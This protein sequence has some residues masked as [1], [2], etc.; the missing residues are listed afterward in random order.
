MFSS[1]IKVVSEVQNDIDVQIL[2]CISD[3]W[4]QPA[5]LSKEERAALAIKKR[6]E[7]VEAQRKAI[8]D[9]RKQQDDFL[10]KAQESTGIIKSFKFVFEYTNYENN[11]IIIIIII[12]PVV[13]RKNII[14]ISER[15]C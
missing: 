4:F 12:L 2:K 14:Q 6:Q 15:V 10:K 8:D 5:F 7:Q 1:Y 13:K 9:A 3:V 11:S